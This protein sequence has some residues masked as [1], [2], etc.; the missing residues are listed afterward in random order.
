M[1]A[2]EVLQGYAPVAPAPAVDR[3]AYVEGDCTEVA[4][5]LLKAC[6][7]KAP[8]VKAPGPAA[9]EWRLSRGGEW[10]ALGGAGREG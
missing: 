2:G 5:E 7:A 9:I 10:R 3:F 6:C 1:A 8:S 4:K